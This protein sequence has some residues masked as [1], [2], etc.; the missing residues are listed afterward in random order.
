MSYSSCIS[1]C[2]RVH[3]P[4]NEFL[5][6]YLSMW[7]STL[8]PG[9][10]LLLLLYFSMWQGTPVPDNKFLLS[11]CISTCD[12]VHLYQIISFYCWFSVCDRV[13]LPDNEFLLLLYF[14]MWQNT[15]VPDN[16]LLLLYFSMW[17]STLVPDN[18][19]LLLYFSIWQSTHVPDNVFLL[20]C[21]SM[22]QLE[23]TCTRKWVSPLVFQ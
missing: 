15:H 23:Y 18:V 20:L 7:Q 16:N 1:V 4:D 14:C 17:Q 10:D 13:H 3:L 21:F 2:D 22:F 12:R 5:L 8:V 19:F 11:S 9:N 6:F